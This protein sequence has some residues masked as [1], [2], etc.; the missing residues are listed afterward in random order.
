MRFLALILTVLIGIPACAAGRGEP[1]APAA[2]EPGYPMELRDG[3]GNPVTVAQRPRRVISLTLTTDEIL[4]S[5]LDGSRLIGVTTYAVDPVLSNVTQAAERIP[6]RLTMNVERIIALEPDLVFTADWSRAEDVKQLRKAGLVVYQLRNPATVAEIRAL[7]R[8]VAE[9][10]GEKKRGEEIVRLMDAR[11]ETT[12][13]RLAAIPAEKRLSVMDYNTWGTSMGGGSS[14]NEIIRLAGLRNAVAGL[15][16]DDWGQVALSKEKLLELDP[17]ILFLPGWVDG[18]AAGS[19]RFLEQIL[20]DPAL[21]DLRCVRGR[22][23]LRMPER[24]KA[25]TS[26]YIV[27]AVETLAKTAYP[28]AF[29]E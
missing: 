22:K 13:K 16:T 17:D 18:D 10:V 19:D 1:K 25:C 24:L 27:D 3:L 9:I 4:L 14:W 20:S 8:G 15:R 29:H 7:I 6:N 23:V 11:L 12:E 2:A 26:Q 5:L 28:D 21:K